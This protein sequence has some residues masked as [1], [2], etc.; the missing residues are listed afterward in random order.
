MKRNKILSFFLCVMILVGMMPITAR[1]DIGPKPSV[2]VT[3][4]GIE[5]ETYYATLLS[6]RES[7]GP[8]SAYD[9]GYASYRAGDEGY[10]IWKKFVEYEDSDGYYFLQEF[11]ECSDD[12]EFRWGYYP[13]TPFKILLYFP[14]Y[15]SFAVSG[16]YERYAFDSYYTVDLEGYDIQSVTAN[17]VLTADKSYDFTWELVSLGVRI[18]L[19]ILAELAIA[20]L[21]G[22]RGKKQLQLLTVINVITQVVLNVLLNIVNYN[23]GQYAFVFYYILWE[24]LVFAMEAVV[25]AVVLSKESFGSALKGKV[26]F[27]ALV[28]NVVSFIVGLWLA[29]QI[30]GIF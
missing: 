10:D 29:Q 21:F 27:Y 12:N 5:E 15:D 14:E 16:I 8:A 13:P 26:I 17:A 2:T 19:T 11:W 20:F 23:K 3:F 7:T 25:Y 4:E 1:A 9:G 24:I 6:E 28:A 30:P 22:L 18:V